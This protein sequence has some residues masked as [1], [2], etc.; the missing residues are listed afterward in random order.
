MRARWCLGQALAKVER[1]PAGRINASR[2]ETNYRDY[3]KDLNLNKNRAQEVQRIGTMPDVD[4]EKAF[5]LAR[6]QEAKRAL[7]RAKEPAELLE[8]DAKEE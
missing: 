4:L 5:A 2:T 3:L 1:S 8:I 7:E 6:E